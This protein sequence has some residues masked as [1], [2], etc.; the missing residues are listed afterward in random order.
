M[1]R[2]Q[3]L[4]TYDEDYVRTYDER[5]IENDHYRRK[6]DF[7]LGVLARLLEGGG[8][9]LD[10]ACPTGYYLSRFPGVPRAG[11][12]LSPAV[13]ESARR[14]NPDAMFVEDGDFTRERPEWR[15]QWDLVT[16]LWYSYGLVESVAEVDRL[17]ASFAGWVSDGGA[18]FVPL[19]DPEYLGRVKVPHV[20]PDAGFPPGRLLITGVTWSWEEPSGKAH[21]NMVAPP[22]EHMVGLFERWFRDVEVV[23]YP[24]FRR[25]GRRRRKG[26]IGRRPVRGSEPAG[27]RAGATGG[28]TTPGP[29]GAGTAS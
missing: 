3:I 16:C 9:W 6:N 7:E 29:S 28:A 25:G 11:L 17:I 8:R 24:P 18:C 15:G 19:C 2:Q 20:N 23:A 10:V 14:A 1:N 22:V 4:D 27:A 13:A 5:F 21:R 12:A 26:L